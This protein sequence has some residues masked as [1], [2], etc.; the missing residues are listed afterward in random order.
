[1]PRPASAGTTLW[2][3]ADDGAR[4]AS[5]SPPAKRSRGCTRRPSD[6]F[7]PYDAQLDDFI[8]MDD[9]PDWAAAPPR[10]L[11]RTVPRG[12][13]AVHGGRAVHRR[14]C[15]RSAR[16][17]S[18]VPFTPVLV[19]HDFKFGNLAFERRG[20]G[21]EASGVFD[22]FEAYLADGEEDIVRMLWSVNATEAQAFVD[23]YAA[24][25]RC[26]T[27]RPNVSRSTRSPTGWCIWEY[28]ERH[29]RG[30]RT[31]RSWTERRADRPQRARGRGLDRGA[32][33]GDDLG[34]RT[35]AR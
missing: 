35:S 26:A 21:F 12:R 4:R 6:F 20:D 28:G 32:E 15:S 2:D 25:G 23:A 22:L 9:F 10:P 29:G 11:A 34:R 16:R 30:S 27:A 24:S 8:E 19:H 13:S 5:P 3:A 33:L 17:R 7:G 14:V 18:S 1:M 31:R